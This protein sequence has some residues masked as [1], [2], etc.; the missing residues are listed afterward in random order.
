MTTSGL[1]S[2]VPEWVHSSTFG[3]IDFNG[4]LTDSYPLYIGA[5]GAERRHVTDFAVTLIHNA[6]TLR[7]QTP[8]KKKINFAFSMGR[9]TF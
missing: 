8:K 4:N 7:K 5:L 2:P 3:S 6:Y 1:G 9:G